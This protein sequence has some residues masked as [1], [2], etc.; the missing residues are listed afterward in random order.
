M[1]MKEIAD[2]IERPVKTYCG[3]EPH[4]V[5]ETDIV[6]RLETVVGSPIA[7]MAI[8]EIQ[9]LR[10]QLSECREER[11]WLL[12]DV[13]KFRG[14]RNALRD[15]L[16]ECQAREKVLIDMAGRWIGDEGW[17]AADMD[18]FD[19]L[20]LADSTALD[21]MLKHAKREALLKV[22][23]KIKYYEDIDEVKEEIS[24]MAKELE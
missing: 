24:D 15:E 19:R 23:T 20:C 22:I 14:E 21:T 2:K 17:S 16:T 13:A 5:K 8:D 1:S 6:E 11:E 18:E 9:S 4:Y 3:G 7:K 10:Q 12:D